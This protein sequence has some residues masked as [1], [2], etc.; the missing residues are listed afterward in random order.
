MFTKGNLTMMVSNMDQ[1]IHFYTNVLGFTLKEHWGSEW[2]E[3]EAPGISIGLH[4]AGE[5]EMTA[6]ESSNMSIGLQVDD[7]DQTMRLLQERGVAFAPQVK[8]EGP[9]KLAFFS[10]PDKH[11]LYLAQSKG[12]G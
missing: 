1:A 9:I 5:H 11:P 2:A 6:A 10:D 12:W 8:D 3:V 7:L 4:P